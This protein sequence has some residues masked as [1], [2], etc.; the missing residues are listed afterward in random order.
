MDGLPENLNTNDLVYFKYAPMNSVDVERS[1]S[2]LEYVQS[3]VR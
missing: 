3:S 1:F 2:T